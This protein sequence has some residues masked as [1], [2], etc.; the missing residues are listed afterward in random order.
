MKSRRGL[1]RLLAVGLVGA[2]AAVGCANKQDT[3]GS[4][5]GGGTGGTAAGGGS[6]FAVGTDKCNDPAKATAAL[7]G[8]EI[9]FGS[10]FPQ[11]GVLAAFA[12]IYKGWD[13]SFKAQNASGGLNGKQLVAITKD[14]GYQPEKTKTN[15]QEMIDKDNV[16]ALMGV[17]GTPNNLA[18]R[19][20]L[21]KDCVPDLFAATGSQLMG[22]PGKYPWV[23]GSLPSYATEGA[24]FASY[25]KQNKPNAKVGILRQNDDFG[26]GYLDA[27]KQGIEGT[28]ITIVGTETYEATVTDVASQVT[29]LNGTGADTLLLA[30]TTLTCPNAIKSVAEK[31]GWNPLVY[32]SATCASKT[33]M[34]LAGDSGKGVITGIYL[35]QP[36]DPQ[37]ANDPAMQKYKSTLAAAGITDQ[38]E[39]DNTII[40]FGYT[41]G[42]LLIQTL[43]KSPNLSRQAVMQTAYNLKG[44]TPGLVL[45]GITVNTSGS[46]DPYPIE[47][48][49]IGSWNGDFFV[50]QGEMISYEGKTSTLVDQ[51]KGQN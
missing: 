10:S 21:N 28:G 47:Q 34:G 51:T 40:A 17:V 5:G 30:V 9:K 39:V 32:V 45:P 3:G 43:Q 19:G 12:D 41:I 6:A 37:W 42:D 24:V 38:K 36:A 16:F 27:F 29:K 49:Q 26:E 22:N 14:D 2:L 35:K 48:L 25:L 8:N 13:A 1:T 44:L 15:V 31:Q 46:S 7:S 33:L 11:S 18:I 23:I 20:S 50:P 4:S